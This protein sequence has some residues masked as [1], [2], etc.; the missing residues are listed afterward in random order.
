MV[1][2]ELNVLSAFMAPYFA[3]DAHRCAVNHRRGVASPSAACAR[4]KLMIRTAI[5]GVGV[6]FMSEDRSAPHLT[7]AAL[8]RVLDE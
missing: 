5:D 6:A 7:S 1:R 4:V 8:V 3:D 2:N